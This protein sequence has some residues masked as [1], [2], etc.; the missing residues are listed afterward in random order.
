MDQHEGHDHLTR[1]EAIQVFEAANACLDAMDMTP[2]EDAFMVW[3]R[4][5]HGKPQIVIMPFRRSVRDLLN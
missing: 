2:Y 1:A 5:S 4:D 3:Q